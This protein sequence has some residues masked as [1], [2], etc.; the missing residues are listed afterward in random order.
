MIKI[1]KPKAT[2]APKTEYRT[3]IILDTMIKRAKRIRIPEKLYNFLPYEL[4]AENLDELKAKLLE[5]W[6]K[7]E[8]KL[9]E[10]YLEKIL[11]TYESLKAMEKEGISISIANLRDLSSSEQDELFLERIVLKTS[12]KQQVVMALH[13]Y[14]NTILLISGPPGFIDKFEEYL[15]ADVSD[16]VIEEAAQIIRSYEIFPRLDE[17]KL[18][19]LNMI[20]DIIAIQKLMMKIS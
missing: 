19:T 17:R 10:K 18:E 8:S 11:E 7:T 2:L 5:L 15:P 1:L 16:E 3:I 13:R 14:K 20:N 9:A 4:S 12:N 6:K